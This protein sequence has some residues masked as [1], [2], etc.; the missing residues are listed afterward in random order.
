MICGVWQE[1]SDFP[2]GC[3]RQGEDG[4]DQDGQ[5]SPQSSDAEAGSERSLLCLLCSHLVT[6]RSNSIG[7][8][9]SKDHTFFTPAGLMFEIGCF[10]HAPGCIVQGDASEDFTWFP[11]YAW[12]H[13][14][15]SGCGAH[16]GWRFES[17]AGGVFFGLVSKRLVEQEE[18]AG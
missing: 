3:F 2:L 12:R 11:D 14:H 15:C 18:P 16:L 8:D 17:R 7:V 9:G 4:S 5:S 13:A 6:S 1:E 10:Y